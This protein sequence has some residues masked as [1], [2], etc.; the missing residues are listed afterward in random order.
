MMKKGNRKNTA[1]RARGGGSGFGLAKWLAARPPRSV[2]IARGVLRER[3]TRYSAVSQR[4]AT[5]WNACY[6]Q[7][8]PY[9][10]TKFGDKRVSEE[11]LREESLIN[12]RGQNTL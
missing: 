10:L 1:V 7:S 8:Y 12:S 9:Y 6:L 4:R 3:F 11:S 5:L 2:M